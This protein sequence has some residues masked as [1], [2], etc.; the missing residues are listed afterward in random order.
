MLLLEGNVFV[1]LNYWLINFNVIC[2]RTSFA[3]L[4]LIYAFGAHEWLSSELKLCNNI[5][6]EMAAVLYGFK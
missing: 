4:A 1:K 5:W 2:T 3:R 6:I